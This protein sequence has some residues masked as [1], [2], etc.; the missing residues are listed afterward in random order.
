MT[1]SNKHSN[2]PPKSSCGLASFLRSKTLGG[3]LPALILALF[4]ST[5]RLVGQATV[6]TS[7]GENQGNQRWS[8]AVES[9]DLGDVNLDPCFADAIYENLL[10]E[11]AKTNQFRQVFRD[12]DHYGATALTFSF[13]KRIGRAKDF[14]RKR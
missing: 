5:P 1:T 13:C 3:V 14:R 12:G 11:L 2:R 6:A 9:V 7:T 8:V 10:Q 4:A